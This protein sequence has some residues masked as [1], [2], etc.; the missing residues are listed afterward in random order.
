MSPNE[1]AAAEPVEI[2]TKSDLEKRSYDDMTVSTA[3]ISRGAVVR[4]LGV[5]GSRAQTVSGGV[6]VTT[7]EDPFFTHPSSRINPLAM[8]YITRLAAVLLKDPGAR[9][10]IIVH[11]HY[12]GMNRKALAESEKRAVAIQGA[13][14][15]RGVALSRVRAIG[16]G[17]QSPVADNGSAAGRKM[18]RRIEFLVRRGN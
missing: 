10:D 11:Y 1:R 14:L 6:L 8:P 2:I 13:L 5:P 17:D 12:E 7:P 4:A 16:V 15:S 9:L 3:P 18:N